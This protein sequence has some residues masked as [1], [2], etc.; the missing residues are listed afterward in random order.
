LVEDSFAPSVTGRIRLFSTHYRCSCGYGSIVADG[1]QVATFDTVRHFREV[2]WA[3]DEECPGWAK[4]IVAPVRPE[5]RCEHPISVPREFERSDL[6]EACWKILHSKPHAALTGDDPLA[7]A[8]AAL[9]ARVG[10]TRLRSLRDQDLHPLLRWA[11]EFRLSAEA[12]F[13]AALKQP[14]VSAPA[15]TIAAPGIA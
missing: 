15:T 12:A 6:H 7:A 11:V 5:E 10:V 3:P 8:L 13:Q 14:E 1:T 9:N 2:E 4:K